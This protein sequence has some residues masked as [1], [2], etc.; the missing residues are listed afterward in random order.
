MTQRSGLLT[1][2]M[3]TIIAL[4][5]A[6]TLGQPV[7]PTA[8]TPWGAP[9]LQGVWTSATYTPLQRPEVLAD[10]EFLTEEET[11]TLTALVTADGVEPLRTRGLGGQVRWTTT[12]THPANTGKHPL[13]QRN[14]ASLRTTQTIF[15]PTDL[16]DREPT[17]RAHPAA[18]T[19]SQPPRNIAQT[20]EP[21]SGLQR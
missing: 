18:N 5:P 9:N 17:R 19:Q 10:Q 13:R 20:S 11:A 15:E 6:A 1:A 14:L 8:R 7:E 16:I 12:Q 3:I 4:T 21:V 2:M